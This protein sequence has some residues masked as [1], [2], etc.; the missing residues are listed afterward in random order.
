VRIDVP[1]QIVI[2]EPVRVGTLS[3]AASQRLFP[4]CQRAVE[5][6]G[7]A[8]ERDRNRSDMERKDVRPTP[9]KESADCDKDQVCKVSDQDHV[10]EE[11]PH[12]LT[13]CFGGSGKAGQ[14]VPQLVLS[15]PREAQPEMAVVDLEPVAG[16][17]VRAVLA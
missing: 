3:A 7:D 15:R 10:G 13:R 4:R 14:P 2:D 1:S 9:G 8:D 17:N 5:M 16:T 6:D 11:H 12:A